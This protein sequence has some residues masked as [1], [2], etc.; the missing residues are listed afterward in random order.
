MDG[1]IGDM[2]RI[3]GEERFAFDQLANE[4]RKLSKKEYKKSANCA[5]L[6]TFLEALNKELV[7]KLG[8]KIL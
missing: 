1:Q 8:T 7:K 4:V 3:I 6:D 2:E 5:C